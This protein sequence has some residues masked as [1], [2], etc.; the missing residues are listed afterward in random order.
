[1][2]SRARFLLAA[3]CLS[4]FALAGCKAKTM[5]MSQVVSDNSGGKIAIVSLSVNDFN[6]SLQGWNKSNT[7]DILTAKMNE[8]LT[9]AEGQLGGSFTVVP[10]ADFTASEGYQSLAG[11]D[12]EVA[13]PSPAGQPMRLFG[14]NRKELVSTYLPADKAPKL[15][16]AAGVNLLAVVY[17]EWT[18]ATGN[19]SNTTKP[20]TKTR[21]SIYDCDG[22]QLYLGRKDEMGKRV[23]GAMG[24][25]VVDL[26][27]VDDWIAAF[28]RGYAA[29]LAG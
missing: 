26:E 20:F 21:M 23:L 15:C 16:E 22:K 28:G 5:P 27:T 24:L 4:L 19:F 7:D 18:T 2:L 29:L 1:M 17:S 25:A 8:M 14:E 12:R 3:S 13:V 9:Q 6:G 11:P 10:A